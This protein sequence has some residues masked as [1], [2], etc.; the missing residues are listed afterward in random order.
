MKKIL[1]YIIFLISFNSFSQISTNTNTSYVEIGVAKTFDV[2]LAKLYK[3]KGS[4]DYYFMDFNNMEGVSIEEMTSFGFYDQDG[5]FNLLYNAIINGFKNK[6][7]FVMLN[8]G[9]GTLK[10]EYAKHTLGRLRFVFTDA[11]GN[12]HISSDMTKKQ[13]SRL[14]GKKYNKAEFKK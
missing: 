9:D 2:T 6:S 10:I 14:F 11:V 4:P 1:F 12:E 7:D 5:A 3:L 8:V 13:F